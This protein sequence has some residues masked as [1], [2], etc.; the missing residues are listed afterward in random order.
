MPSTPI[1][2][3][4]NLAASSSVAIDVRGLQGYAFDINITSANATGTLSIYC[5]NT[6]PTTDTFTRPPNFSYSIASGTFTGSLT[7]Q[8][9]DSAYLT[10]SDYCVVAWTRVSGTG[11][12]AIVGSKRVFF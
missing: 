10:A 6:P 3:S 2:E 9:I 5:Q 8:Q 4:L 7:S 1:S 12:A 11:T